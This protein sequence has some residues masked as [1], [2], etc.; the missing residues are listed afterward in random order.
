MGKQVL[1]RPWKQTL[2]PAHLTYP[3]T[4]PCDWDPFIRSHWL[5]IRLQQVTPPS[6][7]PG[8]ETRRLADQSA[9]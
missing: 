7:L 8:S 6:A 3:F 9:L 4:R 2:Q 5:K 1:S